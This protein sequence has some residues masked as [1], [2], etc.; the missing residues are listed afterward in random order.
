MTVAGFIMILIGAPLGVWV[1]AQSADPDPTPTVAAV[2]GGPASE[3]S[4]DDDPDPAALLAQA[5]TRTPTVA[6][7][8]SPEEATSVAPAAT[9]TPTTRANT[10]TPAPTATAAPTQPPTPTPEPTFS[11]SSEPEC[12]VSDEAAV[13]DQPLTMTCSGF[14][15]GSTV[16][17]YWEGIKQ[18]QT[19]FEPSAG[20]TGEGTF[21]VPDVRPGNWYARAS[22]GDE[23]EATVRLRVTNPRMSVETILGERGDGLTIDVSGYHAGEQVALRWYGVEGDDYSTLRT[24]TVSDEGAASVDLEVPG[25]SEL[26]RHRIAAVGLTSGVVIERMYHVIAPNEA[27]NFF[28]GTTGCNR[29]ALIFNVGIGNDADPIVLRTLESEGVAATMFVMG[30]WPERFPESFQ[31][32]VDD[33]FIVASHGYNAINLTTAG[34]DQVRAEIQAGEDALTAALGR[35]PAPYFT[36]YAGT[37]DD[38]VRTVIAS[39]G[40]VPVGWQITT[41]DW[42]ADVTADQVYDKVV[43]SAYDG[44]IVEFHLD[45]PTTASS[46]AEALPRIIATLR[47]KGYT[48][49]TVPQLEAPC[50]TPAANGGLPTTPEE[51]SSTTISLP[52]AAVLSDP[53]QAVARHRRRRAARIPR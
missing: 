16:K 32:I 3:A 30:W 1:S 18:S 25:K 46:T 14:E 38:R 2:G 53:P 45:G 40:Y 20:G 12:A 8:A 22:D 42:S 21:P 51:A 52:S 26:G 36:P 11:A 49:V 27:V 44:A 29:I 35:P 34:D 39:E 33:G 24:V 7:T 23:R 4:P 31:R 15:P 9:A 19:S 28:Q 47:E 13:P 6:P 50:G 48:F 17:V 10:P 43:N 41:N 37:I 5:T